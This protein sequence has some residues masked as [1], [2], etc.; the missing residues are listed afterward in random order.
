M[1]SYACPRCAKTF[2]QKQKF[3]THYTNAKRKCK[4]SETV[5]NALINTAPAVANVENIPKRSFK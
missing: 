4:I 5:F 2:E 1:V 3:D